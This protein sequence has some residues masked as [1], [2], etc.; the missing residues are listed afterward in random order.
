MGQLSSI[1]SPEYE[2]RILD[3]NLKVVR[4]TTF[5]SSDDA[6]AIEIAASLLSQQSN[7]VA[8]AG[9]EVWKDNT[10][11]LVRLEST[12]TELPE[13]LSSSAARPLGD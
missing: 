12:E 3:R 7:G 5:H 9:F 10:R 4:T 6:Q 1:H 8:L 11:L 13:S 2:C